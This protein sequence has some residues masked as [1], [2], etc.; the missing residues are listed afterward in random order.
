MEL[1]GLSKIETKSG[2]VF[3]AEFHEAITKTP[4]GKKLKDKI[5]DV[6]EDGY[7]ISEK[8]ITQGLIDLGI[9]KGRLDDLHAQGAYKKF[10]MHKI[11]HWL[12]ID[13][14]D[15]GDY[16]EN[17][18]FMKFK[19]GMVTTVE[20]GIYIPSSADVEDKWKGIGIRI[21]D[22][23]LVTNDGNENLTSFVPSDPKEIEALMA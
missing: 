15:A 6:I 18:E 23:I 22:D 14:H 20:P 4:A 19:P 17:G 5:V 1:K 10:Y 21:E 16:M 9:L 7:L 3:D 11:G 13:V 12:G 2:D 8:I